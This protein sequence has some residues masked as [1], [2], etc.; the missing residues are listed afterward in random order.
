MTDPSS[1]YVLPSG[2][3][4]MVTEEPAWIE[5]VG[6]IREALI[7]S[8]TTP[9][10]LRAALCEAGTRAWRRKCT[11]SVVLG[12]ED[13]DQV[14]CTHGQ[15]VQVRRQLCPEVPVPDLQVPPLLPTPAGHVGPPLIPALTVVVAFIAGLALLLLLARCSAP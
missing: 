2:A 9:A 5:V 14:F 15:V 4:V 3:I 10:S 7:R 11:N 8:S 1:P 6:S 13:G 12:L